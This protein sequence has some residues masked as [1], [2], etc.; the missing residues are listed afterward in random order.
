MAG[1]FGS[2]VW[3]AA[4]VASASA[5]VFVVQCG[6]GALPRLGRR[7]RGP[8]CVKA[9]GERA[10]ILVPAHNEAAVIE[11]TLAN[12]KTQLSEQIE[13]WVVADNCTDDT[14]RKARAAGAIVH[15]RT[16]PHK[17]GKGHA[18]EFGV[19]RLREA[20]PPDFV[21]IVDADCR[22]KPGAIA[23]LI[24]LAQET[25][26]P[27]QAE[28]LM[29]PGRMD[30]KSAVNALA[31]LI[32]NRVR[33]LGL[34]RLGLPCQLTGSGMAF[35]WS[36]LEQAPA[37]GSY[38]VE[39]MLLGIELAL[40]GHPPL[41]CPEAAIESELPVDRQAQE[42][43]R[44]RWEHGHLNTL[45]Q[46]GPRLLREGWK[47]SDLDLLA[48]GL[49]LLVPPLSL[50]VLGLAGVAWLG[51]FSWLLLSTSSGPL[52]LA[53]GSLGGVSAC[54]L[55]A[56]WLQGR[57]LVPLRYALQVPGYVLWKL[58]LYVAYALRRRQAHWN[59]TPRTTVAH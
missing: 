25:G 51:G 5:G 19:A 50:L 9:L 44:R 28:Y 58:P 53:I 55:S 1:L 11:A 59:Q 57:Q 32:K 10:V 23:R 49:D 41:F 14:A 29:R 42:G 26:R 39:D 27:V 16:D 17:R 36:L 37:M 52:L 15:E 18:I 46:Q 30:P 3:A 40:R 12:L 8:R 34:Q 54:V 20:G 7:L 45:L 2:A 38:L 6:L 31:F 4:G 47:R 22:A 13:L 35:P 48:M 33:P 43:Q 24:Q 56:W 21:V